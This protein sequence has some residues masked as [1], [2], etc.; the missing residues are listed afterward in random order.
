MASLARCHDRRHDLGRYDGSVTDSPKLPPKSPTPGERRLPHPPSDRYKVPDEAAPAVD[1]SASATRG[2]AYALLAGLSGA[3]ATTVLG[4]VLA[5][6]AGLLIV[7]LATGWAMAVGLRAGG[8]PHLVPARRIRL[9]L[10]LVTAAVTLGQIG[11]WLYA[12]SEGGVLGPFDYLAE[13][14]G[15]LVPLQLVIA[16]ITA[17]ASAR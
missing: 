3:V 5:V 10:V 7:A 16:W 6:S 12:R 4:G 15:L 8:G 1:E 13:T 11:L 2:V 14:F 17:A 9:A